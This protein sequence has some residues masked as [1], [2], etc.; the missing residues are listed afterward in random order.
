M[1]F[2]LHFKYLNLYIIT[3]LNEYLTHDDYHIFL[4]SQ[5]HTKKNRK[6]VTLHCCI[7]LFD[8]IL[9]IQC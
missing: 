5:F 8:L 6:I 2:S 1:R 9:I 3:I 7:E 4:K